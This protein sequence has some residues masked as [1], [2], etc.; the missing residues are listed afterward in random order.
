MGSFLTLITAKDMANQIHEDYKSLL[1]LEAKEFKNSKSHMSLEERKR[2]IEQKMKKI[3][4]KKEKLVKDIEKNPLADQKQKDQDETRLEGHIRHYRKAL[5]SMDEAIKWRD[6]K[7]VGPE[8][9]ALTAQG[10]KLKE[11]RPGGIKS[12]SLPAGHTCPMAGECKEHC[13][14][15]S[16]Q[17]ENNPQVRDTHAQALGLAER[18]DF[19]TK[20]NEQLKHEFRKTSTATY[21]NPFRI[22]A[23]GDFYSNKYAKKW[24][25]IIKENKNIWFYAYT[26]SYSVPALQSL[27]KAI[28]SGKI[29]NVKLIQSVNGRDDKNINP[30][31]PVAVVFKS[32][33]DMDAWNA[34]KEKGSKD[35]EKLVRHLSS[36]K[37]FPKDGKFVHCHDDDTVAAN[38]ANKRI[39]IVEHGTLHQPVTYK[40]KDLEDDMRKVEGELKIGTVYMG[41][42]HLQGINAEPESTSF[43]GKVQAKVERNS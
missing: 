41:C 29:K 11:S 43:I 6:E 35:F 12:W 37:I 8:H 23:W 39:G 7:D 34:G 4:S 31:R 17:T 9:W 10:K 38:P 30:D 21:T 2:L 32:K 26:K 18:D 24:I 25:E 16:G 22:H 5:S 3:E 15:M 27:A 19:I 14:A 13:F 33:A 28:D 42:E 36:L 1:A 40:I 20:M